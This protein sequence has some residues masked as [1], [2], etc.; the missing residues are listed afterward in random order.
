MPMPVPKDGESED[1]FMDRCMGADG[2]V[3]EFPESDQRAAV[4][5]KQFRGNAAPPVVNV[6]AKGRLMRE[7][8]QRREFAF[9]VQVNAAEL[10]VDKID[11]REFKVFPAVM[12]N[13]GVLRSVSSPGP[14]L[15]LSEVFGKGVEG[16]RAAVLKKEKE[17]FVFNRR[18]D[19]VK[20][21]YLVGK[22]VGKAKK[23]GRRLEI[24]RR[25]E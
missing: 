5:H 1:A 16:G 25:M 13:E 9:S 2:M 23:S 6:T 19:G 3:E 11:G 17:G 4:C 14:E 18:N 7:S 15:V 12:L 22:S 21:R 24:L 8:R 20:L 10:R